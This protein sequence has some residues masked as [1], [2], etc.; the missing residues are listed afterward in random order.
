MCACGIDYPCAGC[1]CG[2]RHTEN[3]FFENL[4]RYGLDRIILRAKLADRQ[5]INQQ[6]P[7][8]FPA[9]LVPEITAVVDGI[10]AVSEQP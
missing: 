2:C 4:D 9:E 7:Y 5:R 8:F 6:L 1:S 10:S 3:E